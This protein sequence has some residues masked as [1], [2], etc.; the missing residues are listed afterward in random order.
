[1]VLSPLKYR[2]EKDT[3]FEDI[4]LEEQKFH[5]LTKR[6][7]EVYVYDSY[8]MPTKIWD[9]YNVDNFFMF[10]TQKEI[11]LQPVDDEDL[12]F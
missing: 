1:M 5:G 8:G 7:K 11:A 2:I 6:T 10:D 9:R 3:I 12:P 4:P